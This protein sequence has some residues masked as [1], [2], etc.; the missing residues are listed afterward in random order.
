M[1]GP[2]IARKITIKNFHSFA[3]QILLRH[4][5]EYDIFGSWRCTSAGGFDCN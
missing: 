2:D 3:L 4:S 5:K 1:L